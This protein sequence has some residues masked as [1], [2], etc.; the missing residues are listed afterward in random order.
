MPFEYYEFVGVPRTAAREEIN[1]ACKIKRRAL[2]VAE[3]QE[4][5]QH[6]NQIQQ[7]LLD[8]LARTSY[9]EM[10]EFGDE[11][12][13]LMEKAY[14][15]MEEEKWPDS[16]KVLKRLL[17]LSPQQPVAR[18]LLGICLTRTRD[19]E[20]A[21]K[22]Y[23]KLLADYPEKALYWANAGYVYQER[24]G[25]LPLINIDGQLETICPHCKVLNIDPTV[26]KPHEYF[27]NN[28][29]KFYHVSSE[30]KNDWLNKAREYFQKAVE[31]E[32]YNAEYNIMMA[33]TYREEKRYPEAVEWAEKAIL[34]DGKTD[35]DDFDSFFFICDVYSLI[36]RTDLMIETAQRIT[37]LVPEDNQE[38]REYAAYR[39]AKYGFDLS[40]YNLFEVACA[41]I[42]CALVINSNDEKTR[43]LFDYCDAIVTADKEYQR[44]K[45]DRLLI[46]PV[47]RLVAFDIAEAFKHSFEDR[48]A[49]IRD[50]LDGFG[51]YDDQQIVS[52][53]RHLRKMYPGSYFFNK[54]F[55]DKL[56]TDITGVAPSSNS[57][58]NTATTQPQ[59]SHGSQK[60]DNGITST[61]TKNSPSTE[62]V[63]CPS[64]LMEG[65]K[66]QMQWYSGNYICHFCYERQLKLSSQPSEGTSSKS[67]G[68]G[69]GILFI[70]TLI[71]GVTG[72]IPGAIIGFIIGI[73]IIVKYNI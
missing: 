34:A 7:T 27:C 22:I 52:S 51:Y 67:G 20:S 65:P 6:L 25:G 15:Q 13:E 11:I 59:L 56:E 64:C 60:A 26:G 38:A 70:C 28:C 2:T 54:D 40:E 37:L 9:D 53:I 46:E 68:C 33:R 12:N 66:A 16:V 61:N 14:A 36:N 49:V 41:F 17:V 29:D 43:D 73:V 3:D 72:H 69:C 55:Y 71:G 4:G 24:A 32:A 45:D 48:E 1:R 30:I 39:F 35:F 10:Q 21:G 62:Y 44:V 50:I 23:D 63:Q 19:Y 57:S 47:R 8:D 31:Y 58:T 42:K 18:N 5:L